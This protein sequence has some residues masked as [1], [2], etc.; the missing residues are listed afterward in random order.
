[1]I[2]TRTH[3]GQKTVWFD[4]NFT[5][6]FLN[7]A[8]VSLQPACTRFFKIAFVYNVTMLAYDVT[9]LAY[10]CVCPQGY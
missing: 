8:C 1:M 7:Q 10:V 9:L 2:C 4:Y 6:D 5:L 3:V